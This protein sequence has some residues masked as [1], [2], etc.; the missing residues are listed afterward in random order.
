MSWKW[1]FAWLGLCL[2]L[3]CGC[4]RAR[5]IV[6]SGIEVYPQYWSAAVEGIAPRASFELQ[7]PQHELRYRLLRRLGRYP[8]EVGVIGSGQR[9]LYTRVGYQWFSDSP[10]GMHAAEVARR[11]Q[12]AT[13]A[14]AAHYHHQQVLQNLP[15]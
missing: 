1:G 6:V 13:G 11:Q 10:E 9:R 7:C 8:S 5:P 4:A 12:A 14:A 2:W 15:Q 3:C